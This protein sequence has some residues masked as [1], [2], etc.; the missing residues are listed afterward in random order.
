PGVDYEVYLNLPQKARATPDS[1]HYLGA[2][3]FL[4]AGR[5]AGA[6]GHGAGKAPRFARFALPEAL[7]K[8]LA[9]NPGALTDLRVTFVPQ[10]GTEP[11]RPGARVPGPAERPAVSI[12]QVRL[13]Y[14]R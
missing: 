6:H 14:V 11:V 1:P 9:D 10:T 3:T 13:L 12:R 8:A 4:G 5:H 7:R 2:L